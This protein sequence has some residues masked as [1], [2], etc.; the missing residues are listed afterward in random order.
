MLWNTQTKLM[1]PTLRR[2]ASFSYIINKKSKLAKRLKLAVHYVPRR[3]FIKLLEKETGGHEEITGGKHPRKF[4]LGNERI[5][6]PGNKNQ[7]INKQTA[8]SILKRMGIH[9]TDTELHRDL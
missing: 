6:I 1:D 5:P 4:I 3:K 7:E 2:N 8:K 9:K